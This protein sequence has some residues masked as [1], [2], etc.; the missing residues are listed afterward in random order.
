V[1]AADAWARSCAE[2]ILDSDCSASSGGTA[3]GDAE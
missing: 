3:N 1:M 2:A